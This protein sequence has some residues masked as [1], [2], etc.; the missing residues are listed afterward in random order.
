MMN[1]KIQIEQFCQG[2]FNQKSSIW[3][4]AVWD[5]PTVEFYSIKKQNK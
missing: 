4:K 5:I 2:G 1:G 3:S